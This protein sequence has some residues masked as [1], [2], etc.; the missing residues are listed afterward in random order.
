MYLLGYKKN[1]YIVFPGLSWCLIKN[2]D[3]KL[4][5]D[6]PVLCPC[7][8]PMLMLMSLINNILISYIFSKSSLFPTMSVLEFLLIF[9]KKS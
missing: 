7:H 5:S 6:F 4:A 3:Q 2:L 9:N 8:C 1:K